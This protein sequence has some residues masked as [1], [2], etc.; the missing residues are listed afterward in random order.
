MGLVINIERGAGEPLFR[1]I[2]DQIVRL[3]GS[4]AL[5]PGDRLP[6]SRVLAGQLS[7]NRSTVFKA[8]QE[9]WA[10]GYLE[11]R[12]GSY[13][14]IRARVEPASPG[15]GPEKGLIPWAER[16]GPGCRE[17]FRAAREEAALL[18]TAAELLHRK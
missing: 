13:S 4:G 14:V 8:Y 18:E 9:L 17:V 10:S 7:V 3:V 5:R 15:S 1:Q 2:A 16:S 12:P 6:A 11:S